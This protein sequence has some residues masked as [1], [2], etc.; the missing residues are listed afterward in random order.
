MT[1]PKLE[2]QTAELFQSSQSSAH[3]CLDHTNVRDSSQEERGQ[4]LE[5]GAT[6]LIHSAILRP[7][8]QAWT[9]LECQHGGLSESSASLS[10][11]E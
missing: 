10:G 3:Y 7:Q 2:I 6:S 8:S 9:G 1:Y 4:C 5:Q 11:H